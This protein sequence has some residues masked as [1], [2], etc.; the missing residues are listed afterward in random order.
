MKQRVF[1]MLILITVLCGSLAVVGFAANSSNPS[2][3]TNHKHRHHHHRHRRHA[4]KP[5]THGN[6][7]N[8]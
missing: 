3:N 7:N 6:R 4:R 5:Q 1:A 2:P 8:E